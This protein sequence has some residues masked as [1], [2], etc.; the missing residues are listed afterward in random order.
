MTLAGMLISGLRFP[1][2]SAVAGAIWTVSRISYAIGYTRADM[3]DGKGRYSGGI[4]G[5][6]WA[7]QLAYVAMVGK[8]G[9]DLI[10][11]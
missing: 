4:G 3:K 7:S 10:L 1:V 8:M 11:S 2:A 6:F 5:L 9:I